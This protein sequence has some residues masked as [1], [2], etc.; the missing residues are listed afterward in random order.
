MRRLTLNIIFVCFSTVASAQLI[1]SASIA[2]KAKLFT[3]SRYGI[4]NKFLILEDIENQELKFLNSSIP[5]IVLMRIK[6]NQK[7]YM[8]ESREMTLIG[9]CFYYIAFNLKN[10]KF[11]RLGGFDSNDLQEFFGE[12]DIIENLNWISNEEEIDFLCLLTYSKLPKKKKAKKGFECFKSCNSEITEYLHQK[13]N[14]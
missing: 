3:T 12:C 2:F 7:Y 6:F 9:N 10:K 5:N 1:D 14:K 4:E 11:Y 13:Q 8:G